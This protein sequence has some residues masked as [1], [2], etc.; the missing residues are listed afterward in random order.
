MRP[1]I[2]RNDRRNAAA[3]KNLSTASDLGPAAKAFQ[4]TQE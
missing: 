2:K 1:Q 4:E 3:R